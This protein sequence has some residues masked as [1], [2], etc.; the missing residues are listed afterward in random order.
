MFHSAS[1]L[2]EV[3]GEVNSGLAVV[4]RETYEAKLWHDE[5]NNE[6]VNSYVI[7]ECIGSGSFASVY[8]SA[9]QN[10][11]Y[12]LKIYEVKGLERQ[13]SFSASGEY[14]NA[15]ETLSTELSIVKKLKHKNIAQCF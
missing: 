6:M 10:S 5:D 13:R 8:K 7:G 2:T 15:L 14:C 4:A 12:A 11:S 3:K 1:A 9:H